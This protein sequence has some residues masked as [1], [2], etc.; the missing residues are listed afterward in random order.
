LSRVAEVAGGYHRISA[1][2]AVVR[3][4]DNAEQAG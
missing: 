3:Y 2:V 1:T 4:V